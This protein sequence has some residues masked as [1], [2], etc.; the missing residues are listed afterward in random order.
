MPPMTTRSFLRAASA[1]V[2]SATIL[3]PQVHAEPGYPSKPILIVAPFPPGNSSDVA[4]R[5]LGEYLSGKLGKPVI[6]ENK[7]GASGQIGTGF[8]ARSQPD[9]HT[10]LMTSTSST[11]SPAIYRSIPYNILTDFTPILR[12]A[13][14]PMVLLVPKNAPYD[15]LE[16]F[17]GAVRQ[18]PGQFAYATAG[19][20]TIQHLTSAAFLA[21]LNLNVQN[22]P[23]RGS[24]QALTDLIGGQ[25]QFM[26]D[27]V[28]S[29]RPHIES[30]KLKP[31]A[32]AS[33]QP[34]AML[35]NART[36][37]S[38]TL[39]DLRDFEIEG[40]VGLM[41]PKGIPA[42]ISQRLNAVLQEGMRDP[43]LRERL[44]NAGIT[45][46]PPNTPAQFAA[47]L[48]TDERRWGDIATAAQIPKE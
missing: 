19:S 43:A 38:S 6:V 4:A 47:F 11:I 42:S 39:T 48:R 40:W 45:L 13:V 24:P 17:V 41:G 2:L 5:I 18:Q 26:F 44:G 23:Y 28:L 46:A 14:A 12:V 7:T 15:R 33:L 34:V 36:A 1:L 21:R 20:G 3:A 31:L 27:A 37:A 22:V 9:G 32:V 35:P 30:G 25:V 10:L 29:A 8:V 16:D